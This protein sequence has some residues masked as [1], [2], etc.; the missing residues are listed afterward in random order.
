MHLNIHRIY[1]N[2]CKYSKI[3]LIWIIWPKFL[4]VN[5]CFCSYTWT[6][7]LVRGI[8]HLDIS[9]ICWFS[10][11]SV[12]FCVLWCIHSWRSWWSRRLGQEIQPLIFRHSWRPFWACPRYL[13]VS[14]IK[15]LVNSKNNGLGTTLLKCQDFRITGDGSKE[16]C[17]T[18]FSTRQAMYM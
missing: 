9:F 7:H 1:T 6:V 15:I 14:L 11:I 10:I 3:P 17:C 4:Q 13:P 16:F 5:S 12:L 18:L 8:F 2:R